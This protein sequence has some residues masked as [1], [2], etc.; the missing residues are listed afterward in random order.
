M[1]R[2][3]GNLSSTINTIIVRTISGIAVV[4]IGLESK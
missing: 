3:T 1:V 4:F 2:I